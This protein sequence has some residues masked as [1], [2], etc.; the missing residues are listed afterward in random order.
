MP[1]DR[2]LDGLYY[3]HLL[4]LP[5]SPLEFLHGIAG[6]DPSQIS[7]PG[8]RTVVRIQAGE[9]GEVDSVY[10][11][12]PQVEELP[13]GFVLGN[14][15]V[16][17]Y[18]N[19]THMRLF[20]EQRRAGAAQLEELE[21]V[22]S[23]GASKH[24][25]DVSG[26]QGRQGLDIQLREP[27]LTAQT[28]H[29]SLKRIRRIGVGGGDLSELSAVLEPPDR[30][31]GAGTPRFQLLRG[32]LLGYPDQN[33]RDV[34]LGCNVFSFA[35]LEDQ[36]LDLTLADGDLGGDLAVPQAIHQDLIAQ[37]FPKPVEIDRVALE[38]LPEFCQREL[39]PLGDPAD[40][41]IELQIVHAHP[42]FPRILQLDFF[43]NEA[44]QHLALDLAAIG[45]GRSSALQVL[46]H[47]IH[48]LR[49][50]VL[51]DH[52][53]VDSPAVPSN[54]LDPPRHARSLPAPFPE[55]LPPP[56]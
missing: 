9:L 14:E 7:A 55:P 29:A 2:V 53:F 34:V 23:G 16:G 1:P 26:L 8:S 30:L 47:P 24:T 12:F 19:M 46:P 36:I 13:F 27:L 50:P 5:K 41:T 49:H 48:P 51:R 33:V 3:I 31:L 25:A 45:K 20:H 39:V 38:R 28:D 40:G 44:L 11:A 35:L 56:P 32:G 6:I 18:Q 54:K 52:L 15:L 42:G 21:Q 22:E 37:L 4:Q 10:D 43:D 17:A